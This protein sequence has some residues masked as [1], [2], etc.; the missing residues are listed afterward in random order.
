MMNIPPQQGIE[1]IDKNTTLE[2]F[3]KFENKN[4]EIR[5]SV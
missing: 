1:L 3:S 2:I 4:I 5:A